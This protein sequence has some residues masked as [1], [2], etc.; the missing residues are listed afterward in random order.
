MIEIH[1]LQLVCATRCHINER[2][3]EVYRK[4]LVLIFLGYSSCDRFFLKVTE[5]GY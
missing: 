3:K 4:G 1:T 2:N 5:S